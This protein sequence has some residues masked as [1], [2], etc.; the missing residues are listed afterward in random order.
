M[1]EKTSVRV[2][3][4]G[5]HNLKSKICT[6][7]SRSIENRKW[8]VIFAFTFAFGVA[9]A[10]AQHPKKIPRIGFLSG[11][12]DL[13]NPGPQVEAFRQGLRDRGYTE[14]KN[15]LVEYRYI[16]GTSDRIASLVAEL[17]QLKVDAMLVTN[18]P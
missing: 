11:S 13:N 2:P 8:L 4:S 1:N 9:V 12:G 6:E 5:S 10:Q 3:H 16:E 14:G 7:L 17:V 18:P 15:N